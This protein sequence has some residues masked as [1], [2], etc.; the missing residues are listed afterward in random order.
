MSAYYEMLV[1]ALIV[2]VA[3][4]FP[5]VL[6]LLQGMALMSDAISHALVLGIAIAFLLT[7]SLNA[8]VLFIGACLTGLALSYATQMLIKTKKIYPDAALALM[9]PLFFSFGVILISGYARNVHLDLD[10]VILGELIFAPFQR[11]IWQ[12]YDLGP[13]ALWMMSIILVINL[14]VVFL[15]YKQLVASTFDTIF[16]GTIGFSI[17][18]MHYVVMTMTSIT[19][20]G[21]FDCVGAIVVVALMIV[22]AAGAYLLARSVKDMFMYASCIAVISAYCG[23]AFAWYYNVSIAG[24][25]AL[26]TGI[27]F[28]LIYLFSPTKGLLSYWFSQQEQQEKLYLL[29]LCSYLKKKVNQENSLQKIARDLG[30]SHAR[31]TRMYKKVIH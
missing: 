30:W 3:S 6:L 25:I 22:P 28:V 21:A 23:F 13:T 12:G 18:M 16:A 7:H 24:S 14:T 11:V 29:I 9:F 17:N 10:M 31:V 20:V 4:I 26:T 27:F 19:A 8:G 5:G 15:F 1:I 2:A